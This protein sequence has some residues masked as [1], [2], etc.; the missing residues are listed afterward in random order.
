[1]LMALFAGLTLGIILATFLHPLFL[2]LLLLLWLLIPA[3]ALL[4]RMT[5][6][7]SLRYTMPKIYGLYSL[8]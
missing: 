3:F 7:K 2:L 8:R 6:S 4:R 5:R 1:M